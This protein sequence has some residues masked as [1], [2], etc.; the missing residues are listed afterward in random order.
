M[1]STNVIDLR[2][3]P[4]LP[5]STLLSSSFFFLF[6]PSCLPLLQPQFLVADSAADSA[7]VVIFLYH[8]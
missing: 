7:T 2:K 5:L 4:S 3:D 1:A 8:G 6:L